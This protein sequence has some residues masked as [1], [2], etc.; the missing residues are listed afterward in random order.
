MISVEPEMVI[1]AGRQHAKI[2][3]VYTRIFFVLS[4]QS[5][6]VHNWSEGVWGR[7]YFLRPGQRECAVSVKH[8]DGRYSRQTAAVMLR[9]QGRHFVQRTG[10]LNAGT[11]KPFSGNI[12]DQGEML[13]LCS[14]VS[15]KRKATKPPMEKSAHS[16]VPHTSIL[17]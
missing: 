10:H 3:Y 11:L 2:E 5:G 12:G 9:G 6:A 15:A 13:M 8:E 16:A 1:S 4:A 7:L 17:P 14:D